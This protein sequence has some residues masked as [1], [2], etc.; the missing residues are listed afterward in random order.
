MSE[1]NP[2]AVSDYRPITQH[3]HQGCSRFESIRAVTTYF[4]RNLD[5]R[6]CLDQSMCEKYV[7]IKKSKNR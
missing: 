7:C 5:H 2:Q 1:L 4:E 6:L 3:T